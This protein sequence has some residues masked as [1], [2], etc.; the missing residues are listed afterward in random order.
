[1]LFGFPS[2]SDFMQVLNVGILYVN[3]YIYIQRLF[4]NNALDLYAC[5]NHLKQA[6][7]TEEKIR[8]KKNSSSTILSV[9]I[10]K[11]I[12]KIVYII[13]YLRLSIHCQK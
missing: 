2:N 1:M 11:T 4:N 7:H 10:Y 6:F 5:L 9:R 3:Y 12:M 13:M 8:R